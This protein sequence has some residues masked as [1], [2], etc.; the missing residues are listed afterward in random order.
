MRNLTRLL[1]SARL[2]LILT[3]GVLG[4]SA[5]Q[6][7]ATFIAKLSPTDRAAI[8][9]AKLDPVETSELNKLVQRDLDMARQGN[10]VGFAKT[11]TE[12]LTPLERD[13]SGVSLLT[14]AECSKLDSVVAAAMA[15][16]PAALGVSTVNAVQPAPLK[17]IGFGPMRPQ[18]H[19][20]VTVFYGQGG[21]GS[22]WYGGAFDTRVSDPKGR[23]TLSIGVSQTTGRGPWAP[24]G[25]GCGYGDG[26]GYGYG[27]GPGPIW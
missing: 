13:R 3:A 6:A 14:A 22:S 5:A 11:F 10:V 1:F 26:Y 21:H 25:Y 27:Y 24:L 23:F 20:D 15:A 9:V 2:A 19:G 18:I 8:G 12:R 4:A 17:G 7:G 16:H